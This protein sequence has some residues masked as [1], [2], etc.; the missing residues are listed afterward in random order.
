MNDM[1]SINAYFR[2][3]FLLSKKKKMSKGFVKKTSK[4]SIVNKI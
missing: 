4:V 1:F 2:L 3:P